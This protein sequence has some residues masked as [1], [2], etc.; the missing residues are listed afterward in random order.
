MVIN[1]D[2][3]GLMGI[4]VGMISRYDMIIYDNWVYDTKNCNFP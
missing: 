1:G 4:L 2:S 3:W